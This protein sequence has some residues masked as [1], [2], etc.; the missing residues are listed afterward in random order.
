MKN[1][2]A[3][4][5][6][7]VSLGL[8][9]AVLTVPYAAFAQQSSDAKVG[10]EPPDMGRQALAFPP[11]ELWIHADDSVTWTFNSD[12]IHLA[13]AG[14]RADSFTVVETTIADI[15]AAYQ[16]GTATPEDV[17]RAYLKRINAFDRTDSPQ[18]LTAGGDQQLQPLNSYMH[19][20]A[21]ALQDAKQVNAKVGGALFGIP[22]IVKDNMATLDMPTTAGSVA[23]GG[24]KPQSDATVVRKLREAGAI[25]LGKGT[26]TECANFIAFGM[27]TGY[28]SQLRFQLF[29]VPGADLS[30]VGYGFNAYDPRIDPRT[31]APFNDGRPVLQ[32][33]GSS[34]GPGIA[35]G[36][37][38][39]TVDVG[40]DPQ[41]VRPEHHRRHQAD[42][43]TRQPLR[44]RADHFRPGHRRSDGADGDG[45]REAAGRPRRLR[46]ERFGHPA[47]PDAGELLQRLHAVPRSER[48]RRRAHRGAEEPL[49]DDVRPRRQ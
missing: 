28:S 42:P 44:H 13:T 37:N 8:L 32:T 34:S 14:V 25:I 10:A 46:P 38:L 29:Q 3:I 20:N 5:F 30:K 2:G 35:V 1:S 39:A 19:V 23:L 33:G 4:P 21:H 43:R 11:N 48:A 6:L 15:E 22:V 16:A 27:P 36:D 12:E 9:I 26:L 24:S 17:V 41:P 7:R 45:R 31:T 49:L 18:P 47:L 40:L